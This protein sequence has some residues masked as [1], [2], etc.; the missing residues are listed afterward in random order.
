MVADYS[1]YLEFIGAVYF[2][3]SLSEYLTTKIWSPQDTK[4]ISRALDGLGMK[5]DK[6]FKQ[7]VL[8]ANKKKGEILQG[9]LSKKSLIGLFVVAFLLLFCGVEQGFP[10]SQKSE[11]LLLQL[12]LVYTCA[13]FLVSMFLL[14]WSMYKKWKY[15]IFYIISILCVFIV[16]RWKELVFNKASLE[17]YL[18]EHVGMV[19]CVSVTIPILWQIFI[20]WMHKSV[21]YGYVKS[22]IRNTQAEY[23]KMIGYVN[24]KQFDKLPKQY[25][26]IYMRNSQAAEDTTPQQAMDDSLLEYK[27]I[28]Y[29][30]I[31]TIGLQVRLYQLFISWVKHKISLLVKW[32]K[33]L[34]SSKDSSKLGVT[35]YEDYAK[36]YKQQKATNKYLKMRDFCEAEII[37]FDE[38]NKYYCKYCQSK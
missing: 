8:D 11:L 34:F 10:V 14:Q 25:H 36:K 5:G 7:A 20:T 32:V 30:D 12:E 38:F 24:T 33:G 3:M 18:A 22:K 26:E 21:F 2:T 27:G 29:N 15:I 16:I 31:R 19:V 13:Y 17:M 35:T 4:K 9:E 28:L 23:D 6:D 37:N 1:S